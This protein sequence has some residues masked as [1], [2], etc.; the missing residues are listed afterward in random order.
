MTSANTH[1]TAKASALK[2][3]ARKSDANARRKARVKSHFTHHGSVAISWMKAAR[4]NHKR[5]SFQGYRNLRV[6]KCQCCHT[7]N[8]ACIAKAVEAAASVRS[9][10]GT[11]SNSPSLRKLERAFSKYFWIMVPDAINTKCG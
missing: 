7:K 2:S 9:D 3:P 10:G 11:P 4:S 5:Q 1:S 6:Q 8:R